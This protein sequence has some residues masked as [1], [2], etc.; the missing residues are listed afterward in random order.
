MINDEIQSHDQRQMWASDQDKCLAHLP[1]F[2]A[3]D[4]NLCLSKTLGIFGPCQITT[5]LNAKP[6]NVTGLIHKLS[7]RKTPL[8]CPDHNRCTS[9]WLL[10][11]PYGDVLLGHS[12]EWT[13]T[14]IPWGHGQCPPHPS[15]LIV[16]H[17]ISINTYFLYGNKATKNSWIYIL[18]IWCTFWTR[19]QLQKSSETWAMAMILEDA[20]N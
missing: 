16:Q 3:P 13:S 11:S 9:W 20:L 15:H 6:E 19:K 17:R 8:L 4:S 14:I 7:L 10:K 1:S 5:L 18:H 12:D 2:A